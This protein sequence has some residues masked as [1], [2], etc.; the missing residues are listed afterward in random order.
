MLDVSCLPVAK[1][2][3]VVLAITGWVL[4]RSGKRLNATQGCLAYHALTA[5]ILV[6]EHFLFRT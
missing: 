4:C 3:A 6:I 2:H 5:R 1:V